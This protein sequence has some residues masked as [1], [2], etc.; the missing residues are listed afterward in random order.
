MKSLDKIYATSHENILC[1]HDTTIEITKDKRLTKEGNCILG[2]CASKGCYDLN[3]ELKKE[4]K[5]GKKINV[6]IKVDDEI[7]S[8]YG[9]GNKKLSLTDRK[10]IVFRKS[11]FICD[12]TILIKCTKSSSEL[13]RNLINKLRVRG[14][15]FCLIFKINEVNR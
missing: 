2:I 12:R 13:N 15:R 1:T 10:D 4:I 5:S 14:K 7:D 3:P 6:I 8:F 9:Y 11:D